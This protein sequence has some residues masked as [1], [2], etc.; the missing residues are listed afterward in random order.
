MFEFSK[1]LAIIYIAL[2]SSFSPY[3]DKFCLRII[4][5]IKN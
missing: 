3:F 2:C 4:L 1:Q 5:H